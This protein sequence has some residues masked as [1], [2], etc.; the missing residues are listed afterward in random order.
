MPN[1]SS[2]AARRTGRGPTQPQPQA[3]RTVA[4]PPPEVLAPPPPGYAWAVQGNGYVL[5]PLV[6]PQAFVA[7]PRQPAG[8]RPFVPQAITSPFPPGAAMR[9]VETCVLV[10]PGDRDPYADFMA[11]VPDLVPDD[12]Q[13]DAMA[14]RPNPLTVQE[15]GAAAEFVESMPER[16]SD[17]ADMRR[18]FPEGAQLVRGSAPL[19]GTGG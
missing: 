14:G 16:P 4:P 13:Y 8:V 6:Q 2:W 17:S 12:G 3:P 19:R 10:K 1:W 18:A 7:P 11:S 15:A 9:K 5:V